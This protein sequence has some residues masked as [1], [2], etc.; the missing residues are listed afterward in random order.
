MPLTKAVRHISELLLHC[1][2]SI[3]APSSFLSRLLMG[4]VLLKVVVQFLC[5]E[6]KAVSVPGEGG[7]GQ[8]KSPCAEQTL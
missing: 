3:S 4:E 1:Y 2:F 8:E 5:A 7:K 6:V